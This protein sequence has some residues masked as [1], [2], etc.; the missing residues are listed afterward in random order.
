MLRIV[1]TALFLLLALGVVAL[2][3]QVGTS[4]AW[5]ALWLNLGTEIVGIVLTVAIVEWLF[6]RRTRLEEARKMAWRV[7]H[8]L[9]HAVWVWQGGHREFDLPELVALLD[10]VQDG[11]P[12]PEFTQNLLMH[13]GSAS[14]DTLRHEP[15][16]PS[17]KPALKNALQHLAPLAKIR[18][19]VTLLPTREIADH[20][21]AATQEL[22]V[23]LGLSIPKT[24]LDVNALR[25]T[26]AR[27]QEWR[28]YGKVIGA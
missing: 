17:A 21:A 18:D 23:A 25:E 6:E 27:K 7:L 15:E 11:D 22:A 20:L 24:L 26:D 9:D 8:D 2:A 1:I 14:Q 4:S 12:L 3:F 16:T 28:H 19:A 5:G 13:L 10:G